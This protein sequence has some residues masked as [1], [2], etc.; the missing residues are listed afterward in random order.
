MKLWSSELE[1]CP[2]GGDHL[3]RNLEHVLAEVEVGLD[4]I[5]SFCSTALW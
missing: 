1:N 2:T 5:L 3:Y 4:E